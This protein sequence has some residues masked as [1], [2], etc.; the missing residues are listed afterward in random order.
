MLIIIISNSNQSVKRFNFI[1]P[2]LMNSFRS[3]S[4][5]SIYLLHEPSLFRYCK[6][7]KKHINTL[8]HHSP[9]RINLDL[10]QKEGIWRISTSLDGQYAQDMEISFTRLI[11]WSS[12]KIAN[13][14]Q[15]ESSRTKN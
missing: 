11:S 13:F 9:A 2:M 14:C 6:K 12:S 15:R 8:F 4:V 10:F 5:V 7:N 3:A 1:S